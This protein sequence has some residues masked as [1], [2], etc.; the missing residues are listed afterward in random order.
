LNNIQVR[1]AGENVIASSS[2]YKKMSENL[3]LEF[4]NMRARNHFDSQSMINQDEIEKLRQNK[5][6]T[7][8]IKPDSDRVLERLFN[9]VYYRKENE[10]RA[11]T[12]LDKIKQT[13]W[14]I[15]QNLATAREL[16]QKSELGDL[17]LERECLAELERDLV[18]DIAWFKDMYDKRKKDEFL[19][20]HRRVI[21]EIE[22]ESQKIR[23]LRHRKEQIDYD[24]LRLSRNLEKI[25]KGDFKNIQRDV[26]DLLKET[27]AQKLK[28]Q[29]FN[30]NPS[31]IKSLKAM[32][33]HGTDKVRVLRV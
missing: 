18:H 1:I 5:S 4:S 26:T 33:T 10:G 15:D 28:Q 27:Q 22:A 24:R 2:D 13:I 19:H 6:Q 20:P 31:D 8:L 32:I 14:N 30:L 21:S 16:R 9:E 29:A 17:L 23:D 7:H 3:D 11:K 12:E 25:E